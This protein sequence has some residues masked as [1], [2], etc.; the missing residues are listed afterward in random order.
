[1]KR[2]GVEII[3]LIALSVEKNHSKAELADDDAALHFGSFQVD[4]ARL[5]IV[6]K[7]L[8]KSARDQ[9]MAFGDAMLLLQLL[10][11]RRITL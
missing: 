3:I 9:H 11:E 1:L 2:H 7:R 4:R 5:G 10:Q 8:V 6:V